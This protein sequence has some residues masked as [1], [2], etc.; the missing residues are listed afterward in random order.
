MT[1]FETLPADILHQFLKFSVLSGEGK[2]DLA[3]D[4]LGKCRRIIETAPGFCGQD[5]L[6]LAGR[7]ED[8]LC[9]IRHREALLKDAVD[10]LDASHTELKDVELQ[11]KQEN[12]VLRK[13]LR[14]GFSAHRII[15][16]S[17]AM[18]DL[19]RVAERAAETSVNVLITGE[20]GTGKELVAKV[21][22]YSGRRR[23]AP[24][25]AVNC[26]A[27]PEQLF[28]SEF[29][30]IEKGVATGVEK[31]KGLIEGA[32]GG[33]LFLD[34]IGDMSPAGQGKVLRVLESGE[35]TPVGSRIPVP[36]D[37]RLVSATNRDLKDDIEAGRFRKDLYYRIKVVQLELPPLRE[38][39]DDIP[40]LAETFLDS[41]SRTL[42]R[43]K[44]HFNRAAREALA[45]Y[46][47]PGNIRELQNEVERAVALA[48]TDKIRLEDL[49]GDVRGAGKTV[50]IS[51]D[52]AGGRLKLAEMAAIEACLK[53]CG[54]NRTRAA[55]LL[56]ISRES[57]RRKLKDRDAGTRAEE[58]QE[59]GKV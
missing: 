17:P 58:D 9:R 10:R 29:F 3:L 42:G 31:R 21:I 55:K 51:A 40:L 49:S 38:R 1:Q 18:Q 56:G 13:Q 48:Y 24:F 50:T 20:T 19:L 25:M 16:A 30:G 27:V 28:E 36:V 12:A 4:Q 8:M 5:L 33:T 6:A 46:G 22:H 35:V 26:T 34:E 32:S 37:L 39:K 59:A 7:F 14:R 53:E 2:Y 54:G 15:G 43:G 45:A 52:A 47:W 44:M 41:F 23:Q 11:L 57:L